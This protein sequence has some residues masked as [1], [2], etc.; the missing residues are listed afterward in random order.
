MRF[1]PRS[2]PQREHPFN[3]GFSMQE[4]TSPH[5]TEVFFLRTNPHR[6]ERR[7]PTSAPPCKVAQ[8]FWRRL[9]TSVPY[10][11]SIC[12]HSVMLLWN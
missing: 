8:Y 11:D 3:S 12:S 6:M 1:P 9:K 10:A 7:F 4:G 5:G 2:D